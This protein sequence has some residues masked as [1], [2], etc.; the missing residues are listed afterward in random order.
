VLAG[1]AGDAGL[2]GRLLY[3]ESPYGVAYV[4]AAWS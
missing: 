3:D 4:V 2:G 1:A